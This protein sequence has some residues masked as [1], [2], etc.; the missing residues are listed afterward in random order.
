VSRHHIRDVQF[1]P[2]LFRINVSIRILSC[3]R[4]RAHIN[5]AVVSQY[6]SDLVRQREPQIVNIGVIGRIVQR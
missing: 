1:P 4:R 2:G 5:I 3:A 6:G